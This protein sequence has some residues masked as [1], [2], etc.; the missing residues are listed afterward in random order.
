MIGVISGWRKLQEPFSGEVADGC[1]S[2]GS[3]RC[4]AVIFPLWWRIP[5]PA[6][7]EL[8]ANFLLHPF[9]KK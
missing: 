8:L 2:E 3:S 9:V 7:W 4:L 5:C 6:I 1:G